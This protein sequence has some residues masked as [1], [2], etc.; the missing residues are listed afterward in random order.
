MTAPGV[1]LHELSAADIRWT[2][3]GPDPW[4]AARRQ[5]ELLN[6]AIEALPAIAADLAAD[7]VTELGLT[8]ADLQE[9][10]NAVR[11]M[12]F[13]GAHARPRAA[14]RDPAAPAAGRPARR[15]TRGTAGRRMTPSQQRV[16]THDAIRARLHAREAADQAAVSSATPATTLA[17]VH[18]VFRRWLGRGIRPACDRC[19]AC[20]GRGETARWRP[21][22]A[23]AGVRVRQREDGDGGRPGRRG[24][25]R[26]LDDHVE[27]A[28]LSATAAQGKAKDATGGLLRRIGAAACLVVKDV[29]SI[30]A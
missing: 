16:N 11:A 5:L 14:P 12:P 2:L 4:P 7:L 30:L 28:L 27:G 24:R 29:T 6:L 9:E 25:S 10:L 1:E 17:D 20:R 15:T 3:A 18:A 13:W 19:G 23:A 26:H 22:M 8:V 21:G